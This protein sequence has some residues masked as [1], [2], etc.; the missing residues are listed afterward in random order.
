MSPGTSFWLFLSTSPLFWLTLT[1]GAYVVSDSVAAASGRHPVVNPV[2][3]TILIVGAVLVGS[4]TDYATYFSG[5]QFVHVLLGPATVALAIPIVRYRNEIRRNLV[6]LGIALTAGSL[7]GVA[8]AVL[9]AKAL[10]GSSVLV[11]SVAPKSVTAPIAMGVAREIG[12]IPE[13]TA[14]IVIATG[15]TGAIMVTPL[16]NALGL[17]DWRARGFAAGLAAHGIGTARALQ[18]HPV[19]GTFAALAMALNG[20]LTALVTPAVLRLLS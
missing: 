12:G 19:A 15:I 14:V 8:S 9:I 6:V 5:A 1:L 17:G 13:L 3:L 2:L 7:T 18:V 20:L 16:M 11:A 4:G 10:G